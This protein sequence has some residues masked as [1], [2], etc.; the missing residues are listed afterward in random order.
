VRCFLYCRYKCS[1]SAC[2][3]LHVGFHQGVWNEVGEWACGIQVVA[4]EEM[5]E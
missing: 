3:C 4:A 1:L 5:T 2:I